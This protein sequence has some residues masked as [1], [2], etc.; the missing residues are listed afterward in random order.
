M[1]L[2]TGLQQISS[3]WYWINPD[4]TQ[5]PANSGSLPWNA[6]QPQSGMKFLN[7]DNGQRPSND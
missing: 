1:P 2:F 7:F 3:Q 5:S 4:G 6:T